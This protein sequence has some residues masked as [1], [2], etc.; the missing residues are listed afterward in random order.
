MYRLSEPKL[1]FSYSGYIDTKPASSS[2][3]RYFI[4]VS[5]KLFLFYQLALQ[6]SPRMSVFVYLSVCVGKLSNTEAHVVIH[7]SVF[8]ST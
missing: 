5:L 4:T 1:L 2:K 8:L 6:M 7:L 3:M